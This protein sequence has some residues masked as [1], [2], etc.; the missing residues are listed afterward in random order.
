MQERIFLFPP[1]L[2]DSVIT[3]SNKSSLETQMKMEEE[4]ES[5]QRRSREGACVSMEAQT[6]R[7]SKRATEAP[8]LLGPKW[9][10]V[11]MTAPDSSA[12]SALPVPSAPRSPRGCVLAWSWP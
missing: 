6:Q 9:P 7:E 1:H 2:A 5:F 3:R 11:A 10:F 4:G 8:L 12:R